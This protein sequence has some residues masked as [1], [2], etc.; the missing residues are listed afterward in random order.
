MEKTLCGLG[1]CAIETFV[2]KL[3]N[4]YG[5]SCLCAATSI[6]QLKKPVGAFPLL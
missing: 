2:I 4:C 1:T 6:Y 3:Q 5:I